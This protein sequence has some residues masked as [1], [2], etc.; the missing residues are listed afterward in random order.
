MSGTI[1]VSVDR[2]LKIIGVMVLLMLSGVG[3]FLVR[4]DTRQTEMAALQL[5]DHAALSGL[6]E[7]VETLS[8]KNAAKGVEP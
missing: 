8:I 5:E 6:A 2:L 7:A 1:N 4:L 3:W